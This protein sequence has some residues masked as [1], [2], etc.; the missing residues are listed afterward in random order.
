MTAF[1]FLR[2]DLEEID[3]ALDS[4]EVNVRGFEDCPCVGP[5]DCPA[6][7]RY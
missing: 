2:I 1:F 4:L 3:E 7:S 5:R 6:V